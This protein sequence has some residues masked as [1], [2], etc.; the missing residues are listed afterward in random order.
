MKGIHKLT[1]YGQLKSFTY[2]W[3]LEDPA[4]FLELNAVQLVCS[5]MERMNISER[6]SLPH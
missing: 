1:S 3:Y 4:T 6:A 2:C 5:V